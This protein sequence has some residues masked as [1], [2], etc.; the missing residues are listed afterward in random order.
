MRQKY[1]RIIGKDMDSAAATRRVLYASFEDAFLAGSTP[2]VYNYDRW[3]CADAPE[4]PRILIK[5]PKQMYINDK[6]LFFAVMRR[7]EEKF[8]DAHLLTPFA[9]MLQ[10]RPSFRLSFC[11]NEAKMTEAQHEMN[12]LSSLLRAVYPKLQ[13]E[14]GAT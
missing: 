7:A 4:P 6:T 11:E 3:G 12:I 5:A 13:Q 9:V 14:V 10:D 2:H 1:D 8:E